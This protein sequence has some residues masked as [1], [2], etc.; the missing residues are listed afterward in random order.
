[1]WSLVLVFAEIEGG[2][3][4]VEAARRHHRDFALEADEAFEDR[5][6][7]AEGGEG[8]SEIVALAQQR[9]PLAVIAEAPR[10][11]HRRPA[12]ARQGARESAASSTAAKGAMAR[13]SRA[14]K[15]FSAS[16]SWVTAS[17]RTPGRR[18]APREEFGA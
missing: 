17:A 15:V 10:L 6:R 13:P 5:R 1:M 11:Q 18:G 2:E 4:A 14:R 3:V 16:R 12:E 8:R 9:L 7:A